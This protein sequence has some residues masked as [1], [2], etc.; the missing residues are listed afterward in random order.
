MTEDNENLILRLLREFR[1]DFDDVKGR[2]AKIDQRMEE[3]HETMYTT[4]GVAFHAK[5]SGMTPLLK[6]SRT[7][8]NASRNWKNKADV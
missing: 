4:A 6:S 2:L 8:K 5:M 7:S 1:G 3:M